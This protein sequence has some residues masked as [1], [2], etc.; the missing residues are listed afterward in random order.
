M[1]E[2]V[3]LRNIRIVTIVFLVIVVLQNIFIQI[4]LNIS[5]YD[6]TAAL[7][8]NVQ[9]YITVLYIVYLVIAAIACVIRGRHWWS[10]DGS[11][12]I[13]HARTKTKWFIGYVAVVGCVIIVGVLET[14]MG[15]SSSAVIG[16]FSFP[17]LFVFEIFLFII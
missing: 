13:K 7:L 1:N 5:N 6:A 16:T 14:S 15:A 12:I 17:H 10:T 11:D 8:K 9:I 4:Y 3:W 2:A